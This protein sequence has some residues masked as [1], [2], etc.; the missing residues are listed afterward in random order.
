MEGKIGACVCT[1]E[2]HLSHYLSAHMIQ[3]SSKT[4]TIDFKVEF[5][6]FNALCSQE[7]FCVYLLSTEYVLLQ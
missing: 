3:L 6:E 2:D 5:M 7:P 1:H 4:D